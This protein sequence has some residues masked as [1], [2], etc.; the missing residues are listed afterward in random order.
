MRTRKIFAVYRGDRFIDVGPREELA[1]RLHLTLP[2]LMYKA[3]PA[4]HRRTT[5]E[6]SMRMYLICNEPLKKKE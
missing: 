3:S 6:K 4:Y 2:T 5:Y 1:Q